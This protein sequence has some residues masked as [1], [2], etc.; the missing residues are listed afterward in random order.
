MRIYTASRRDQKRYIDRRSSGIMGSGLRSLALA[1]SLALPSSL[2]AQ[3]CREQLGS[4][5]PGLAA[6]LFQ[7]AIASLDS[8][9]KDGRSPIVREPLLAGGTQLSITLEGSGSYQTLAL[10]PTAIVI[11]LSGK[12]TSYFIDRGRDG[13]VD[14]AMWFPDPLS[15]SLDDLVTLQI[16][17]GPD[18]VIAGDSVFS[19]R[20]EF[21]LNRGVAFDRSTG[22]PIRKMPAPIVQF[23]DCYPLFLV[24][25]AYALDGLRR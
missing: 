22:A 19:K 20:R 18:S 16:N 13:T 15:A 5:S 11:R 25:A 6:G 2:S 8:L 3:S 21:W 1:V 17:A 4:R 23:A 24:R 10:Q 9:Y 14:V 12:S 7:E